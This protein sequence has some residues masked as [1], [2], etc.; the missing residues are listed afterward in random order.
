MLK[1][2]QSKL[3]SYSVEKMYNLVN[4]VS[5]YPQFLDGCVDTRILNHTNNEM[6]VLVKVI[7]AGITNT[8]ITHNILQNNKSIKIQLIKGPFHKLI[9]NWLFIPLSENTCKVELH[10]DFEFT[11]KLIE[12]TFY[13]IFKDLT[14]NIIQS[15]TQRAHK[16]YYG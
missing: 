3:L 5:S 4:D 10:L 1:I 6:I 14:R 15:F 2:N 16:V 8:L 11:N 7:K 9:G 13:Q 12:L